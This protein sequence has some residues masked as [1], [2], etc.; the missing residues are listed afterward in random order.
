MCVCVSTLF[1]DFRCSYSSL[2]SLFHCDVH[3]TRYSKMVNRFD[4]ARLD[5]PLPRWCTCEN[6]ACAEPLL[7]SLENVFVL[8]GAVL[9]SHCRHFS[10]YHSS[11]RSGM[12][13]PPPGHSQN[14]LPY[15]LPASQN[16]V[17]RQE[18]VQYSQP[19]LVFV[20]CPEPELAHQLLGS[21]FSGQNLRVLYKVN[22]MATISCV[23]CYFSLDSLIAVFLTP[24]GTS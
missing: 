18:N 6:S 12:V 3:T 19:L 15:P 10:A 1:L 16:D 21:Q 11:H 13:R 2:F 24:P 5:R 14:A 17:A 8:L 22:V 9:R 4:S 20:V 23:S 7:M